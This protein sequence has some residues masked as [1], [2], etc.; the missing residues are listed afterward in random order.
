MLQDWLSSYAE[1]CSSLKCNLLT[2]LTALGTRAVDTNGLTG[3]LRRLRVS[4]GA[5]FGI[6]EA[7]F[8]GE[9]CRGLR[10]STLDNAE[11]LR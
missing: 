3:S 11:L 9:S 10:F 4:F 5:K 8:L 6:H 7:L 1:E 2:N